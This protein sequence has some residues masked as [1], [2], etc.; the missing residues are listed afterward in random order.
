MNAIIQSEISEVIFQSCRV[1]LK[2]DDTR[3]GTLF[4]NSVN[5]V[6]FLL[7]LCILIA[8]YALFCTFRFHRANWH[9]SANLTEVFPCFFLSCKANARV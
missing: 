3:V 7:C 2:C 8:M 1:E 9:S 5:C 6:F 4:Y